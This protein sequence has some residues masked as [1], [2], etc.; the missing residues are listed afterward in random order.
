MDLLRLPRLILILAAFLSS[1]TW[2]YSHIHRV[3]DARDGLSLS[4]ALRHINFDAKG[5]AWVATSDGLY[6]V[7]QSRTHRVDNPALSRGA[8][9]F[10]T[11]SFSR[12][13]PISESL[14]LVSTDTRSILLDVARNE[15]QLLGQDLFASFGDQQ[16]VD[17]L[18]NRHGSYWLLTAGGQLWLLDPNR[19]T[20]EFVSDQPL[21]ENESWRD[22]ESWQGKLVL[23][24]NLRSLILEPGGILA[25]LLVQQSEIELYQLLDDTQGG[26][27]A[28]TSRGL[29]KFDST[30]GQ[31]N[32]IDEVSAPVTAMVRDNSGALWLATSKGLIVRTAT[33]KVDSHY[34]E[35]LANRAG[36]Q[37]VHA[38]AMDAS[39]LLWTGGDGVGVVVLA[40][41]PDYLLHQM[42]AQP[43][44]Q[45]PQTTANALWMEA[46]VAWFGSAAGL[47][48]I[49]TGLRGS[50][51][52]KLPGF[53][54][55]DSV[56]AITE[57]DP[58]NLLVATSAGLY[59]LGKQTNTAQS[60]AQWSGHIPPAGV[61]TVTQLYPDP[62]RAGWI[63]LAAKQGLYYWHP[64]K[65]QV[66]AVDWSGYGWSK[67][68]DIRAIV[69]D[70]KGRLWLGGKNAL[71]YFNR[72]LSQFTSLS[73]SLSSLAGSVT[74][75]SLLESP[76][77]R[78]LLGT[79]LNGAYVLDMNRT[80]LTALT[81]RCN[82]TRFIGQTDSYLYL[83]CDNKLL[84]QAKGAESFHQ[85]DT[86]SGLP[87]SR[88]V[89][90]SGGAMSQDTL[91]V[92]AP[93]GNLLLSLDKMPTA[94]RPIG[95][96]ME[97]VAVLTDK[98]LEQ[99]LLPSSPVKL[100]AGV[101]TVS[102]QLAQSGFWNAGPM[103][104]KYRLIKSGE[105]VPQ[106]FLPLYG[107]S[108]LTLNNPGPGSYRLEVIQ[109][110]GGE[111]ASEPVSIELDIAFYWWQ[112]LW[113]KA[114]VLLSIL[115]LLAALV[116]YRQ[117]QLNRTRAANAVLQAGEEKLLQALAGSDSELWEWH[118]DDDQLYLSNRGGLLGSAERMVMR[119]PEELRLYQ[120]DLPAFLSLCQQ[121][122]SGELD[123]FETEF[124]FIRM[125]KG[126][127]WMRVRGQSI[128]DEQGKPIRVVGIFS[129]I[130]SFR[131][132]QNK[133]RMLGKA[134]ESTAE[135]VLILDA[136]QKITVTN[137]SAVNLLGESLEG[138]EFK[139]LLTIPN[140]EVELFKEAE[141]PQGWRG[142][143]EL[144]LSDEICPVWLNVS[145]MQ[146]EESQAL[147]YVVVFSD[148][149]E[150][151]RSEADLRRLANYD[152]LT[153]LPNR[154]LFGTRLMKTILQA[155][156]AGEKLALLFLD[157]DRFKHVNDSF[158]HGMGDALLV[159][160]ASRLH[161]CIDSEHMLCR[162][163]GDEFVLLARDAANLDGVNRLAE[164]ILNQMNTPFELYGREF[165]LS[166]SIGISIW[167]DDA[168]QPEALIK[169]A[170]QAMYHAKE[171]GRC[172]FQYF[173]SERNAEALY[174]LRLEADL[175]K[176]LERSEFD[177]HFQPQINIYEDEERLVGIEALVRWHHPKD[178]PV[179]PDIFVKIAE[180]CGLVK[181]LDLWVLRQACTLGCRWCSGSRQP[182]RVAVNIS[183]AHFR[184]ADFVD[185]VRRI[186]METGMSPDWL[187]L[188]ITEGVLMDEIN[189][190]KKHLKEL[191]ELGIHV[192]ID[193]FGTGYSSLAY[194][195]NFR[196]NSL[197]I[198]RTF[199]ID[200]VD[201]ASDQAIVSSI[202]ELARNLKLD[203]VAEGVE[204]Q[205]QLEQAFIRGCYNI[206]GYY[207]SKPMPAVEMDRYLQQRCLP[208]ASGSS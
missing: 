100:P 159:E 208:D 21:L 87:A 23:T 36:I 172:N 127:G 186:L 61:N 25:T 103:Q 31:L 67:K 130:T 46:D 185:G 177:V 194:L 131:K 190:A 112:T 80:S 83:G 53:S 64:G 8:G 114:S 117:R 154:S 47:Y 198:D 11:N 143:L 9:R 14:V 102:I 144:T 165:F 20:L 79:A 157:L 141:Q 189:L 116:W 5:Y 193:D 49:D 4:G 148:I 124:R 50:T 13:F 152:M 94:S 120:D 147:Y 155:D 55:S 140:L 65:R 174:H 183:A 84:L 33:G 37:A 63:W 162:F 169:N 205:D 48:R 123:K 108:S 191:A 58:Y 192:A 168:S 109:Q 52:I 153:G 137:R 68:H 93:E 122:R 126:I 106:A 16:A 136:N 160:A 56:T 45:L 42:N 75:T 104:L 97:S 77:D 71:G 149:R 119:R 78:L 139:S 1:Q 69:R 51:T 132:L 184:S 110:T 41:E 138:R 44:Y 35:L 88:F 202:V 17:L 201:N 96:H 163:G 43:P 161:A 156:K 101:K 118:A 57:L 60:I 74:V 146:E 158:G 135:G 187:E 173:S 70:S 195:R 26:L 170:D 59:Q 85:F 92:S 86:S 181:A 204:T 12:V 200:I 113:F 15:V 32:L 180:S 125:D 176:A 19:M 81:T 196:V 39:G 167:P 10:G 72:D 179:R 40:S 34:P 175:R 95:L 29:A 62:V 128:L 66:V 6:R 207:F 111:W 28:A 105:R 203:V 89:A 133:A 27:W 150:R 38:L 73:D 82:A 199:L 24:S 134:F 166:A 171:E 145:A 98:G 91:L 22:I 197:K 18:A 54:T 7:S 76:A 142:E 30:S 178:G 121:L 3:I 115:G 129:D 164:T 182:F 99:Q 188:E 151:K 107:Q 206:Q 90:K 2:G